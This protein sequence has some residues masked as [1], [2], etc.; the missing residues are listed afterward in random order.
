MKA[1]ATNVQARY[2]S[3]LNNAARLSRTDCV[4]TTRIVLTGSPLL[5]E[6]GTF[7]RPSLM[8]TMIT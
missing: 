1:L 7:A 4:G 6:S 5:T 2:C 3:V 8:H